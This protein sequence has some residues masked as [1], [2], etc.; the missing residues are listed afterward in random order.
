[1]NKSSTALEYV[2][3]SYDASGLSHKDSPR[4]SVAVEGVPF[5]VDRL[6]ACA[7]KTKMKLEAA[8]A[9]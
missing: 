3:K 4:R 9:K 6:Y 5:V 7:E 1:M 8:K 2:R